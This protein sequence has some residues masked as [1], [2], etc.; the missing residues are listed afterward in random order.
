MV[1]FISGTPAAGKSTIARA[2]AENFPKSAYIEVD[3]LWDMVV[4][5]YVVPWDPKGPEQFELV[6]KNF[7]SMIRNFLGEGYVVVLDYVFNDEQVKRYNE[8][9]GDVHGFLLLP[10]LETL[11]KRDQE[12]DPEHAMGHRI[13]ALYPDFA[14]VPHPVL[15]VIDSTDQS[16]EETVEELLSFLR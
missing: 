3:T 5:G 2:L 7:L 10:S 8:L 16:V 11:K 13:D 6:E 9:L 4:G 14:D 15:K 1:I 12:R